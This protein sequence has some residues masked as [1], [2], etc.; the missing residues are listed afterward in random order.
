MMIPSVFEETNL[1]VFTRVDTKRKAVQSAFRRLI[2]EINDDP[3]L[4]QDLGGSIDTWSSTPTSS[5][6][7]HNHD[8]YSSD[9]DGP[10][11]GVKRKRGNEGESVPVSPARSGNGVSRE[12]ITPT[13]GAVIP[14]LQRSPSG[15][16]LLETSEGQT[17]PGNYHEI[18]S[19]ARKKATS[20]LG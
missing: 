16:V 7:P 10:T 19:P 2:A 9:E 12:Q 1:R 17:L 20:R 4:L 15:G 14:M 18:S 3:I 13:R 11:T 8:S 6:L 5:N